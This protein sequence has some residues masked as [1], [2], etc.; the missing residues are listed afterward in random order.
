LL[1]HPSRDPRDARPGGRRHDPASPTRAP[2]K[3]DQV[4]GTLKT[5]TRQDLQKLLVG[6]GD[7][8]N[9]KPQPGEDADQ[10]P[11]TKGETA[12]KSL[13]ASYQSSAQ[14][15]RGGAIVNDAILGTDLHDLSR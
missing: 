4:L 14:A 2:V 5:D 11:S 1:R 9:G 15:L 12:A 8:I 13:N 7:A 6:Y 3:L 10:D